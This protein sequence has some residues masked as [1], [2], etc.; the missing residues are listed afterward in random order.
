MDCRFVFCEKIPTADEL[1]AYY[2]HYG[3]NQYLSP[4][5]VKRYHE[6]LDE[7]EQYRN[8]GNLLDIGCANGLFLTEA[9][10]RGWKVYGTEYADAQIKNGEAR[11]IVMKQGPLDDQTFTHVSFDVITSIEVIEHIN[12]PLDEIRHIHRMLRQGGLFFCTTPN[13]NALSRYYLGDAYNII[14]Y[15]EHL[16]YYTPKTMHRLLGKLFHR[17]KV[18]TTGISITRF[19]QSTGKKKQAVVSATS[20]D[21]LL[22][23]KIEAKGYLQWAKK[24]LNGLLNITGLGYSLKVWYVK[25]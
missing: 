22:R 17:K 18:T 19:H 20:D 6:W 13:F 8:T 12:N 14:S 5:T 9:K 1:Q 25:R 2:S 7:F 21:E 16:S 10:K 24:I 3:L 23:Q 11:G 15:P 4:I